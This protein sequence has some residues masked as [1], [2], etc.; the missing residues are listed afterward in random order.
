M[1][2]AMDG[3][4]HWHEIRFSYAASFFPTS[5][6]L[7]GKFHPEQL[8]GEINEASSGGFYIAKVLHFTFL[9]FLFSIVPSHQG[10]F[11]V[12]V[13]GSM[14]LIVLATALG[15]VVFR[16]IFQDK[17]L[18]W[19]AWVCMII[20]PITPYLAGKLL[21]EVLAL[22][23]V[24]M[25]LCFFVQ[26]LKRQNY[27]WKWLA[28][29]SGVT[30][31]LAGLARLDSILCVLG[32]GVASAFTSPEPGRTRHTWNVLV[33]IVV[34]FFIGYVAVLFFMQVDPRSLVKYLEYYTQI[35]MKSRVMSFLG[36]LTFAG[37]GYLFVSR[38]LFSKNKDARKKVMLLLIWLALSCG[39][40]VFIT[41]SYMIEPRY[42]LNG[43]FPMAGLGALGLDG[44]VKRLK[45]A[46][47]ELLVWSIGVVIATIANYF[48]LNLMP[49]EL[50][51]KS[52]IHVVE[53]V[54]EDDPQ[55]IILVPWTY[56]DF[57]FLRLMFPSRAI[58]N[59]NQQGFQE[60]QEGLG[61][62]ARG[63]LKEWYAERYVESAGQVAQMVKTRP[64]FY[65]GWKYYPPAMYVK[66][67]SAK[68][69]LQELSSL[70]DRLPLK[71]HLEESWMWHHPGFEMKWKRTVGQYEIYGVSTRDQVNKVPLGKS[72][73]SFRSGVF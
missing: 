56:T 43:L 4:H 33:V 51:R 19:L 59:V 16:E 32:F 58:K 17:W 5:D 38:S 52:L 35:G 55:A 72:P 65:L 50:D 37:I 22:F 62:N 26:T 25:S 34:V 21:S 70:I 44:V 36:I 63:K 1:W 28:V 39:P 71:N 67:L 48:I 3:L 68:L 9:K 24:A 42:L 15:Y 53:D 13:W 47:S 66:Q 54:M 30:L 20:M 49:Y 12:A 14:F 61:G 2:L 40:M 7:S 6:I 27:G 46:R 41:W 31:L 57:H 8:G 23:W 73:H 64:V 60:S 29:A 45:G 18:A 10:G 11:I 69:G